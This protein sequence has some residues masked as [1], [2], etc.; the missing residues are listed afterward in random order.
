MSTNVNFKSFSSQRF[1]SSLLIRACKS[2]FPKGSSLSGARPSTQTGADRSGLTLPA[3]HHHGP[4]VGGPGL[5]GPAYEGEEWQGVLRDPHVRPL[6]VVELD[7]RVL[8]HA[9]LTHLGGRGGTRERESESERER[10]RERETRDQ[11]EK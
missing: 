4:H 1:K 9:L 10:E 3:V 7:H 11:R 8:G 5:G 6:G 2:C